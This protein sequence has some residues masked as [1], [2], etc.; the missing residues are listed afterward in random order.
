MEQDRVYYRDAFETI[1]EIENSSVD[2]VVLD[3]NYSQWEEFLDRGLFEESLRILRPHGNI[4]CFTKQPFDFKLRCHVDPYFR[5]EI[6][7][8]FTNGGAWVSKRMPLVSHQKIYNCV[9]NPKDAYFN[10]RTGRSYADD[11]KEFKRS[12]KVFEGYEEQGRQFERHE[13]GI[14]IRDHL[15]FNKP[16]TGST[17][18]KPSELVDILV[19]SYC[20]EGGL[21]FDPFSGSG[22][23]VKASI[24]QGKHFIGCELDEALKKFDAPTQLD[25]GF[26]V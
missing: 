10:P 15:H 22:A 12:V 26:S 14:W 16:N 25:L 17:P 3:P 6:V 1:S 4:L 2:L 18:A 20:P 13:D 7:W 9:L 21:V 8:T 11:T 24:A 23:F 19:R 5:R